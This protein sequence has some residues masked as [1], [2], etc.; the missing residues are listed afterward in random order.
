MAN[1]DIVNPTPSN[2][3]F[4]VE[5]TTE[6]RFNVERTRITVKFT[7]PDGSETD[8]WISQVADEYGK[9]QPVIHWPMIQNA[10]FAETRAFAT[11]LDIAINEAAKLTAPRP[12][13]AAP[14]EAP[15]A[16]PLPDYASMTDAELDK[17][18]D[19]IDIHAENSTE[20]IVA[21]DKVQVS[22]R[23]TP[24]NVKLTAAQVKLLTALV[25]GVIVG[26]SKSQ[27]SYS[28]RTGAD[29]ASYVSKTTEPLLQ[30]RLVSEVPGK[31]EGDYWQ[32]RVLEITALGRTALEAL[33][34]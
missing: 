30:N 12:V 20:H 5:R 24:A 25:N 16:L 29:D 18:L 13:D 28:H 4:R 2:F 7:L 17:A 3:K 33:R 1:S 9:L 10:S 8:I 31:N 34:Q 21:I 14:A 6:T 26:R 27:I 19:E 22:R 11:A 32:Y 15:V 23:A